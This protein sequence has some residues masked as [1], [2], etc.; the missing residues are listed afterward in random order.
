MLYFHVFIGEIKTN[1]KDINRRDKGVAISSGYGRESNEIG[2]S[3]TY[4]CIIESE[5]QLVRQ[6]FKNG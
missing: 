5:M 1:I 2:I 3:E 4:S 6:Y